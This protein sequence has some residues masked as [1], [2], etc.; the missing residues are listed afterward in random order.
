MSTDKT[1]WFYN[2]MVK[3][4]I[5]AAG[6]TTVR[7]LRTSFLAPRTFIGYQALPNFI[8]TTANMA[9]PRRVMVVTDR[10]MAAEAQKVADS[11]KNAGFEV[12]LWD[13]AEPEVPVRCVQEGAEIACSFEPALLVAFGGGSVMDCCKAV[14]VLYERT[15]LELKDVLPTMYLGLRKKALMLAI[16]TTSG[17]GSESTGTAVLTD[18]DMD[19]PVKIPFN[20]PEI[21]PDF[22]I[23]DGRF[24]QGMPGELAAG[25]GLDALT[26]AAE[27]Y[28]SGWSNDF[29]LPLALQAIKLVL[30]YLP[31][32]VASGRDREARLKMHI[33][34]NLAGL[35][36]GNSMPGI[37]HSAG[38][39]FGKLFNVHHGVAVGLFLPY[40]IQYNSQVTEKGAELA[41]ELGLASP[42]DKDPVA[43]LVN[44]FRDLYREVG[45]PLDGRSLVPEEE[46][47]AKF[48]DLCRI[49]DEDLVSKASVRP[50]NEDGY[51]KFMEY[52]YNG[53]DIDY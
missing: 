13:G 5:P 39:S 25:T 14:W 32:S 20:S 2:P 46:F 37:A 44:C 49:A 9:D 21:V 30:K 47:R 18:E 43:R 33:A 31:R 28:L 4:L 45:G 40:T 19:P 34:S 23:I 41:R 26:H 53:K 16:P 29:T 38:H 11:F 6:S 1:W 22:A 52:V 36:F 51:R 15:D 7:G 27:A 8:A 24:V 3:V 10:V 17:T 12:K 48:D 50:I 42:D 35:A